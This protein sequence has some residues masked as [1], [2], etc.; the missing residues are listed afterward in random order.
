[1]IKIKKVDSLMALKDCKKKVVVQE[2]QYHCSKCDIISN[3]FKYSLMVVFEIY[4]HSG[5]HW[6]VM[7]DSSAEKLSKKTTSEIGVIIEAHG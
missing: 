1:M 2:G 6:L 5:S 7:F 3:N 4:D